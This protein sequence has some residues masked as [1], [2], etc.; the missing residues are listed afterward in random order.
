MALY[1]KLPAGERDE[2]KS[3]N[4]IAE[5]L[6]EGRTSYPKKDFAGC[7]SWAKNEA[8]MAHW[9]E[10]ETHVNAKV[11]LV[12]IFCYILNECGA[13]MRVM[14]RHSVNKL[15]KWSM[16]IC[17]VRR[18]DQ[19]V[20][21]PNTRW[22]CSTKIRKPIE[23]SMTLRCTN[24]FDWKNVYAGNVTELYGTGCSRLLHELC[25]VDAAGLTSLYLGEFCS[26]HRW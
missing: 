7:A 10:R 12:L 16:C 17:T 11:R 1:S 6:I 24:F 25:S 26:L 23:L 22:H 9:F 13:V 21:V 18:R 8:I 5:P 3:Q 4:G 14:G 20:A 19:V 2:R 15:W